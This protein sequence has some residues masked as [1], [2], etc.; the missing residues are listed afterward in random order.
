MIVKLSYAMSTST[1]PGS[2]PAIAKAAGPDTAPAV[3]VKSGIWVIDWA[4]SPHEDA[5]STHTGGFAR[6]RARSSEVM[7]KAPAPSVTRQQSS[8]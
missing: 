1:S 7:T 8:R 5:P 2:M 3:V 4:W 6:S